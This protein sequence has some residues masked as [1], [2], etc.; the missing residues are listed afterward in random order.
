[1]RREIEAEG[2]QLLLQ[3]LHRR[4]VRTVLE[5][6]P[7]RLAAT[8]DGEQVDLARVALGGGGAGVADDGLQALEQFGPVLMQRIEGSRP[9]QVLQQPLVDVVGVGAVREAA[10]ALERP[11]AVAGRRSAEHTSELQSLMRISYA[12]L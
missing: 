3:P 4:P 5:T 12:V 9:N 2:V 11:V 6:Q 10:E 8:V 7:G 1:M